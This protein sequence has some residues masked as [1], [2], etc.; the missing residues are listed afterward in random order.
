VFIRADGTLTYGEV[1]PLIDAGSL[2]GL[3][4]GLIT[5][6]VEADARRPK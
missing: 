5:P 1:M 6:G 3:K 4:I 2:L